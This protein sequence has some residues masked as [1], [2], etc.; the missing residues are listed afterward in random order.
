MTISCS[1]V[2]LYSPF[3][4][5]T[6]R[7]STSPPITPPPRSGDAMLSPFS[8]NSYSGTSSAEPRTLG[9]ESHLKPKP[10]PTIVRGVRFADDDDATD[11]DDLPLAVLA[12]VQKKRAEREARARHA[13]RS[14][15]DEV[16]R[17]RANQSNAR[18]G[19]ERPASFVRDSDARR[20]TLPNSGLVPVKE[21]GFAPGHSRSG[22]SGSGS[23]GNRR[24]STLVE[25]MEQ[26]VSPT[27]SVFSH[28]GSSSA[29]NTALPSPVSPFATLPRSLPTSTRASP[30]PLPS[31][32]APFA[33]RSITGSP[34]R[35]SFALG[36][37]PDDFGTMLAGA[38]N[39]RGSATP[40]MRTLMAQNQALMAH[41]QMLASMM[42][43]QNMM[44]LGLP[45]PPFAHS[46]GSSASGSRGRSPARSSGGASQGSSSRRPG[47]S[48]VQGP[49]GASVGPASR[50]RQMDDGRRDASRGRQEQSRSRQDDTRPG[51]IKS[52]SQS[53]AN[54]RPRHAHS[55]SDH[56]ISAQRLSR[57]GTSVV[58]PPVPNVPHGVYSMRGRP[59][60][61]GEIVS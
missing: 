43:G 54:T 23:S 48:P 50:G 11:G 41:N 44:D 36:P 26:V 49:R 56:A 37:N 39:S 34:L 31:P 33:N 2:N 4:P 1:Y 59:R 17:A 10:K 57:L 16:A 21:G 30:A 53:T 58:A 7:T 13:Q 12:S 35:S 29:P 5:V 25:G 22:S 60:P 15:A 9:A 47:P 38:Q 19:I 8:P 52:T 32:N 61:A 45:N 28:S 6:R 51:H 24:R 42:M 3:F 46:G 27:R 40:D 20:M 55:K 18:A 14:Y